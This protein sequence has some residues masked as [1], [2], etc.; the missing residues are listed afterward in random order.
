[1]KLVKEIFSN[2]YEVKKSIFISF[3]APF[4]EF[5]NLKKKLKDEHPK[6]THIV[7]A[8]RKLNEFDQI[9]ENQSDDNEPKG[10]AGQPT[11]AVL[12]GE[13]IIDT[14]LLT[15]RYFGG[16]K[17]GVGGM[18]RGYSSAAKGVIDIADFIPYK[19]KF[20]FEFETPYSL[21]NRYEHFLNGEN[22]DFTNRDFGANSV[23]W[24]LNLT[25]DE[26]EKFKLFQKSL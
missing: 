13:D 20:L 15:V 12:R 9:V 14:A 17:L 7:Y 1:M 21:V 8:Y 5:D 6:A 25:Q 11:L 3:L 10:C 23:V 19:K 2:R 22:I 16:T 4:S 18:I 26:I 24:K